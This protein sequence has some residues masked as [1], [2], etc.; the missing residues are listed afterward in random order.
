MS[1]HRQSRSSFKSDEIQRF[2]LIQRLLDKLDP[3]V[4]PQAAIVPGSPEPGGSII[5]FPGS[6]NPPTNAHLVMLRQAQHFEQLRGSGMV[7]AALSKRTTDK[8][9]VERPLLVDRLV[10]L[11][12][13]LRHH[14]PGVGIMLFNRG[15]YV[16][17]AQGIRAAFP[18]VTKLTFLLGFDKIVEIF[19]PH[20]YTDR[21]AALKE[22]FSLSDI[23]VAPRADAG[24][25]ALRALLAEPENRPYAG[26]VHLLPLDTMYRE[27]SSTHIRQDFANYQ[28]DVPPEVARF[29]G[30]TGVYEKPLELP[31]GTKRDA[32]GERIEAIRAITRASV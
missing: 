5:V 16:E 26:A 11:E 12:M 22:L 31:D 28:L 21:D 4:Q 18:S 13:V 9:H 19:D 27:V 24:K 1:N 32:Y 10:L 17:Q 23:L 29:I 7:Y 30:K 3:D 2:Q 6:F 25:Q 15:L 8:E 14:A 20:Y